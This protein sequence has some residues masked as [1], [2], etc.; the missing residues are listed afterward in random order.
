MTRYYFN[1]IERD[2]TTTP[3][4]EGMEL[5]DE[6]GMRCKTEQPDV[7]KVDSVATYPAPTAEPHCE[8]GMSARARERKRREGALLRESAHT[9]G[10]RG[11]R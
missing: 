4:E 3:D 5:P 8:R 10:S 11:D 1:I 7:E 6:E 2:G 9:G